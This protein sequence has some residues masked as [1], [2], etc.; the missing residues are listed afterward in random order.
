MI[1]FEMDP[2]FW[3]VASPWTDTKIYSLVS[4]FNPNYYQ[5]IKHIHKSFSMDSPIRSIAVPWADTITS[6]LILMIYPKIINANS[7]SPHTH[8]FLYLTQMNQT[9]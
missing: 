6:Y 9:K 7:E 4:V 1:V 2:P 8:C 5:C 3:S